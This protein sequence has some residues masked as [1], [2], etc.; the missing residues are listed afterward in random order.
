METAPPDVRLVQVRT[1]HARRIDGHV[2]A[3]GKTPREGPVEARS[4]GLI[5]DEVANTRVHGGPEKAVY[6][7]AASNY[8]LWAAENPRHAAK[9]VPGGFGENLLIEGLDEAT[10]C[11]GDRWRVGT[12]LVEICQPRQPCATLARWFGDP[13]IVKAMVLNG[14]SGWYLR[15]AQDG[16]MT[17][18]DPMQ[19]E[20][21]PAGAWSIARVLQ[22]SYRSPPD[23]AELAELAQAPGLA[24]EWATWAARGAQ[25]NT[26][27]AKPL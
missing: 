22:A 27:T 2:T 7:Y 20:Y 25:S 26:P 1:G 11:I 10:A 13:L 4:L 5:G 15:V 21:R 24:S 9:L 6:A 12:A 3:Y 17:A 14:R 16:A 8:P 23:R 18:G 19:L